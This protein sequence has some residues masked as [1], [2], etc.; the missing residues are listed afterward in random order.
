M[1]CRAVERHAAPQ[2]ARQVGATPD[3]P[4]PQ[5]TELLAL[6]R[7]QGRRA[8]DDAVAQGAGEGFP[9]ALMAAAL[10]DPEQR[11]QTELAVARAELADLESRR[12]SGTP[13]EAEC[14]VGDHLAVEWR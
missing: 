3:D 2:A 7:D 8:L 1:T 12:L 6:T 5:R 14:V 13:P 11:I 9:R 4:F 10:V